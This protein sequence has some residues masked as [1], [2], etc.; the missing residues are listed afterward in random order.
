MNIL[1]KV[2][3]YFTK[4]E[5]ILMDFSGVLIL[6][7]TLVA[8]LNRY[9][10]MRIPMSWYEEI[11][12]ILYMILIYWGTSHVA[13][14]NKHL[15]LSLFLDMLKGKKIGIYL[16]LLIML[17]CLI[18]SIMGV[19][20]SIKMS[21]VFKIK[22]PTLGIQQSIILFFTLALP[23]FGLTLRYLYKFVATLN[24]LNGKFVKEIE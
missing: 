14:D 11:V 3:N 7:T 24:K 1:Y 13:K 17:S 16:D 18:I 20:F 22:T 8:V 12:I 9:F 6:L 19:Y 4:I 5:E 2:N 15:T 10:N 21:L 23:F